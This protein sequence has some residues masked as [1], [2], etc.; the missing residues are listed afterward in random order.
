[1]GESS[2]FFTYIKSNMSTKSKTTPVVSILDKEPYTDNQNNS[3][4]II[5]PRVQQNHSQTQLFHSSNKSHLSSV[6]IDDSTPPFP[7]ESQF[8]K[9]QIQQGYTPY[10]LHDP[11]NQFMMSD[12]NHFPNY[13][14]NNHQIHGMMTSS[15]PYYYQQQQGG[16][17]PHTWG[18]MKKVESRREAALEKFRKKRKE[19]CYDKKIRYVNRKKL[20][21]RR[22]RVRGQFV[23]KVNGIDVD[24]NGYPTGSNDFDEY[25]E[26]EDDDEVLKK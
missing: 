20:A 23:R 26:E 8:P 7:T 25:R 19:R 24:L 6:S 18:M 22:P 12:N 5:M 21:E 2:A 14:Y 4:K 9:P 1:M 10:H 17:H 15:F 13:N 3:Q 11:T 16:A